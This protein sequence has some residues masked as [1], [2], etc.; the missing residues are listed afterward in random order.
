[1]S[2]SGGALD[3]WFGTTMVS[4]DKQKKRLIL[5][6]DNNI[7]DTNTNNIRIYIRVALTTPKKRDFATESL[8]HIY[9]DVPISECS[10][11]D[12][13]KVKFLHT[14]WLKSLSEEA[15]TK[16][17]E[18]RWL[19]AFSDRWT[20][21]DAAYKRTEF[22]KTHDLFSQADYESI[23]GDLLKYDDP[24]GGSF[25]YKAP[26]PVSSF[27]P[28]RKSPKS[29]ASASSPSSRSSFGAMLEKMNHA[30]AELEKQQKYLQTRRSKQEMKSRRVSKKTYK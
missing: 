20:E 28:Y 19:D 4:T 1:M 9:L 5:S 2:Y 27:K 11:S 6:F 10:P 3:S 23:Y 7:D 18:F 26:S 12:I 30:N 14:I 17:P 24:F 15:K 29:A 16:I 8:P 22:K 25:D 21:I 13:V